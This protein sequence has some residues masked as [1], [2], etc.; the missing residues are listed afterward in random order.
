M[1]TKCIRFIGRHI[2]KNG[3]DYFSYSGSGFELKVKPKEENSSLKLCLNSELKEHNSQYISIYVN[4]EIYSSNKLDEGINEVE[5]NLSGTQE[6]LIRLIKLNEVYLSSI[7]VE[8]IVLEGCELV[9]IE[10]SNRK[11]IG[12][13]GDSVTCGF[14]LIDYQ[15]EVFKMETEDFRKTYGFLASF[16]LNMDYSIVARSGISIAFPIYVDKLFGEIYDTVDMTEK[17]KEDRLLDYAIINLGANDNSGLFQL[18][19]EEDRPK[20]IVEFKDKFLNLIDR[21]IVDNK[22]V[23]IVM[24]YHMLPLEEII[25]NAIKDVYKE[26]SSKYTNKIKLL[27]CTPN[28]DGACCH[29]YWPA[30]K[31]ASKLLI[32]TIKSL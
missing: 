2:T 1:D 31:E 32:E 25:I 21:I 20:A 7:L 27:E 8:D 24:M 26:A 16:A 22:D 18:Y 28:S 14:G 5:I 3:K 17:C 15:G 10:P 29:P 13:F 19:K 6:S 4:D 9:E 23:K 11:L 12:F 30:H